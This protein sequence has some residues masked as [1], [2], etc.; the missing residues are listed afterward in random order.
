M[1]RVYRVTLNNSIWYD[2]ESDLVEWE[3]ILQVSG[4]AS[5]N[6]YKLVNSSIYT[7]NNYVAIVGNKVCSVESIEYK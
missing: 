5:I 2:V 3:F 4:N 7:K 6:T 1:K